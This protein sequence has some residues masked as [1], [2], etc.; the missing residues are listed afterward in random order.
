[1]STNRSPLVSPP[2]ATC[3]ENRKFQR[4]PVE[5]FSVFSVEGPEGSGTVVNLSREGCT[6]C[7]ASPLPLG[8]ALRV[9][10]YPGANQA[11][12][13]VEV[14]RVRWA[15]LGQFGVEF[16]TLAPREATRLQ[17]FLTLIGA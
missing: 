15:T 13:E 5:C 8:A 16:M 12:I 1:M 17:E 6:V 4:V 14:A 9:L 11:P 3:K 10:I 7:S 2:G